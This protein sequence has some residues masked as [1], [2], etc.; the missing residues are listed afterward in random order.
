MILTG[1]DEEVAGWVAAQLPHASLTPPYRTMGII[2]G[3]ELV[4]GVVYSAWNGDSLE[5][6]IA[7]TD[8]RWATPDVVADIL[9]VPF[10]QYG[11]KSIWA[12]ALRKN[13][14]VRRLME[15]V[16]FK[17]EGIRR[18]HWASGR[19]ACIY[20]MTVTDWQKSKYHELR[21]RRRRQFDPVH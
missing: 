2:R 10:E 17:L 3:T 5:I 9:A 16:G 18:R 19:D 20:G 6:S 14:R 11:A 12:T 15:G 1:R 4:C 7:A 8:P 13:R 21:Q